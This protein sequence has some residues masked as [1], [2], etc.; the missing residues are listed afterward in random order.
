M[1]IKKESDF[2]PEIVKIHDNEKI[3]K[4]A[5]KDLHGNPLCIFTKNADEPKTLSEIFKN[6][7]SESNNDVN[8]CTFVA[9]MCFPIGNFY[10]N[11]SPEMKELMETIS[12][13]S[14]E[15]K[16]ICEKLK[17]IIAEFR[18]H[19]DYYGGEKY[20]SILPIIYNL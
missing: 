9:G 5:L 7:C 6:V 4:E 13:C 11:E 8:L 18:K 12:E 14:G 1:K 16:K 2:M 20:F 10:G 3:F 17:E 15:I 19:F